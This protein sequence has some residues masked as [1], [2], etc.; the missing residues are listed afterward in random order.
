[1][2]QNKLR[3]LLLTDMVF[4][5]GQDIIDQIRQAKSGKIEW[6]PNK[7]GAIIEEYLIQLG[8]LSKTDIA[9]F[10]LAYQAG[11]VFLLTLLTVRPLRMPTKHYPTLQLVHYHNEILALKSAVAIVDLLRNRASGTLP[12]QPKTNPPLFPN[13]GIAPHLDRIYTVLHTAFIGK[14]PKL[15]FP[16]AAQF[17]QGIDHRFTFTNPIPVHLVATNHIATLTADFNSIQ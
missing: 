5:Y 3:E 16:V 10:D 8:S 9:P 6:L 17:L 7:S 1:M 12:V 4:I 14:P 15:A 11:A 2:M 13:T